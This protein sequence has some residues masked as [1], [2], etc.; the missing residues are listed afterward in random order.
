MVIVNTMPILAAF[1]ILL[2][3]NCSAPIM[4]PWVQQWR[5]DAFSPALKYQSGLP[6]NQQI[7]LIGCWHTQHHTNTTSTSLLC[8]NLPSKHVCHKPTLIYYPTMPVDQT[9]LVRSLHAKH[10]S[11]VKGD[12]SGP[13]RNEKGEVVSAPGQLPSLSSKTVISAALLALADSSDSSNED[14]YLPVIHAPP[15]PRSNRFPGKTSTKTGIAAECKAAKE[16]KKKEAEDKK[17]A[18]A[19]HKSDS[20]TKKTVEKGLLR[21]G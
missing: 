20:L 14:S 10:G 4:L 13:T 5:S 17:A 16:A 2:T 3:Y 7:L 11:I 15:G 12:G 18:A 9:V 19:M 6:K 1:A 8:T 21:E